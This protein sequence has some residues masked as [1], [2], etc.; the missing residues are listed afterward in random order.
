MLGAGLD[1]GDPGATDDI[2]L[3]DRVQHEERWR[4]YAS[5]RPAFDQPEPMIVIDRS[6]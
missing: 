6:A 1:E 5:D 3:L 2:L 4:Q